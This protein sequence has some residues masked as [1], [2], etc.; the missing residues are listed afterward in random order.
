MSRNGKVSGNYSG[1]FPK[2]GW[3][4]RSYRFW[5]HRIIPQMFRRPEGESLHANP[6]PPGEDKVRVTWIG[7]ASFLVQFESHSVLFDPNWA[8]WH[9]PVKRLRQPGLLLDSLPTVDL[10][11]VSHAHFD[12]MH[13]T[14][15]RAVNSRHGIA[16]PK[17]SG[18][19]VKKLGFQRVYEMSIWEE[20][21]FDGVDLIHTPSHHWG[22]RLVSDTHRDYG[23]FIVKT[24]TRNVY[25]AGD[26][27]YFEGFKEIGKRY[28]IDI[29]LMPIGAYEAPSGRDVH[30]NPEEAVQAFLDLGA[31]TLIP[32]HFATFPL[33]NEE[34]HE[35][36]ERLLAEAD[37]CGILD[38]ILILDPGEGV[39][40]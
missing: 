38:K 33:G 7:H 15:L 24:P 21:V 5:R 8:T 31:K 4:E 35:P 22:A 12:H 30:L 32:M 40:I 6:E 9:G 36:E 1:L 39:E 37:R 14:S 3:G 29:A 17:G 18:D 2:K 34:H 26:S 27:A 16:V 28:E 11:C 20:H 25:H 19:L 10:V 23:G 13:R